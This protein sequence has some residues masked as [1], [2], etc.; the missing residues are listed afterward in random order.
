ML[1]IIMGWILRS[2]DHIVFST[3]F[4]EDIYEHEYRLPPH[5]VIENALPQ[6]Q[7]VPHVKHDP[8]RLLFMGRFVAFKN[9][10]SLL[11]AVALVSGVRLTLV[12]EGPMEEELRR[13]ASQI[14]AIDRVMFLPASTGEEKKNFF[15]EQDLLVIPSIT[16]LSPNVALEARS[17][18][19]P[20]LLTQETG[21]SER[22][23]RGMVLQDCSAP[24][25]IAAAVKEIRDSYDF[26]AREASLPASDR[27][28]GEVA[29]EHLLLFDHL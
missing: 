26:F 18:G 2:F 11:R 6:G 24:E 12:G 23:A 28:W 1:R 22:L 3:F 25:M 16:E 17:A 7:P 27:G 21:L 8:F 29:R 14:L 13:L 5:S 20:V 10:P 4:E 19:L 9:L 15:A